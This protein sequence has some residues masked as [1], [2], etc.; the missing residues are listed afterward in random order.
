MKF[1]HDLAAE[2]LPSKIYRILR[3]AIIKGQLKP[4]EHL[5]QD[6]LAK[7]LGVSRMPIREAVKQLAADGYVTHEP[8]KGAVVKQFTVHE[9]KEIYF[10][11]AKFEPLAAAESLKLCSDDLVEKLTTLNEQMKHTKDINHYIELNIQFHHLLIKDCPWEKLNTI[12]HNLWSGF[13][14]Q[15]PHLL[16]NQV[17]TSIEEHN[18]I[19]QALKESNIPLACQVLEQHITRAGQ[20]VLNNIV[21]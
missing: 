6:E 17:K 8:H 19:V 15:T 14:Q 1:D 18:Q 16:S 12:I 4:G 13:P 7:S 5:V 2:T 11:R 10:L 3:E 21:T 9:L 20:D